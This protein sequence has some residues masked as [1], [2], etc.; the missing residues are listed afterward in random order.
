MQPPKSVN[1]YL[2]RT[3]LLLLL[4]N[5]AKAQ[6]GSFNATFNPQN[7]G[8]PIV[9]QFSQL[10]LKFD[11]AHGY[12]F[13]NS[14]TSARHIQYKPDAGYGDR[15]ADVA[16]ITINE[17]A[18]DFDFYDGGGN[19]SDEV[20]IKNKTVVV[21]APEYNS[22]ASDNKP[23]HVH[24][25][26]FTASEISFTISGMARCAIIKDE[27]SN[28]IPGRI[29]GSGHFYRE[30]KYA[31]SDILPG[32]DCD[33]T[34]YAAVYDEENYT[35]TTSACENALRN[36][37]FDA[38]QKS[39]APLFTNIAYKGKGKLA[40]G[41]ID[42]TTIAGCTNINVPV[43]E[44][45]YC[46]SDYYHNGLTGLDAQ[47]KNFTDDDSYGLRFIKM[48]TD[49]EL[50]PAS[51]NNALSSVQKQM[52]FVDSM[53]KLM[54]AKKITA[55]QFTKT[56]QAYADKMNASNNNNGAPDFKKMEVEHNLYIKV[57]INASNREETLVKLGDKSKT[58]VQHNVKGA[59]FE[60]F[61][62][63]IKDSDG[64]WVSNRLGIYFGKFTPPV[65][66]K[67]GGGFDAETTNAVY[68]VNGNKLTVYNVIIK[69][70]GDKDLIEKAVAN[71]DF[72]ALLELISK[73]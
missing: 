52:A 58:V 20:T 35:R 24:I 28:W 21:S 59:A 72:N 19:D 7:G 29:E 31:Q 6:S 2:V 64:N 16:F 8:K 50:S 15:S 17:K 30:P 61:S 73:Q 67:S 13:I 44:R 71:I 22:R 66:G 49:E 12:W 9:L 60:I 53:T 51:S 65:L 18:N 26:R 57:I 54:T 33:P 62:P 43:K 69:M 23:L 14:H 41:D 40:G 38:V 10:L 1:N 5:N 46:F 63:M 37:V 3:F 55:E 48:P 47:K 27:G 32:C 70:E 39:M 25:S 36:K 45:P 4:F 56:I 68:P 11:N 42:I 34:I